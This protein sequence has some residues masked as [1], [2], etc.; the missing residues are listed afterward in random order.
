MK[1]LACIGCVALGFF[2]ISTT[3]KSIELRDLR[4]IAQPGGKGICTTSHG[5]CIDNDY[6]PHTGYKRKLKAGPIGDDSPIN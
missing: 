2:M 3:Y 6:I 5:M 1:K 4:A